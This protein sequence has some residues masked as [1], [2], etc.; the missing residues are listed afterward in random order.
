[1]QH[2]A[3]LYTFYVSFISRG[4]L[5]KTDNTVTHRIFLPSEFIFPLDHSVVDCLYDFSEGEKSVVSVQL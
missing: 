2:Y 4:L 5:Y 1:M 3:S